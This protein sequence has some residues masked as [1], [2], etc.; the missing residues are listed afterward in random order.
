MG[1]RGADRTRGPGL[2]RGRHFRSRRARWP[3]AAA[4]FLAAALVVTGSLGA[5][6][7]AQHDSTPTAVD[8]QGNPVA[9]DEGTAPDPAHAKAMNAVDTGPDMFKVPSVGLEI[10]LG[11]MNAVGGVITP[12]GFR[13]AY[14][15]RNMGVSPDQAG[16]GTVFVV[17]HSLRGGGMGP[18]NYLID[19]Q[20][21]RSTVAVGATIEVGRLK[22]TVDGSTPI[23][24]DRLPALTGIWDSKPNRLVVITCLLRPNDATP[25]DNMV[26][27]A[28]RQP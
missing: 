8:M 25:I 20:Q 4:A 9:P 10:P 7:T 17:M 22:Y 2:L 5:V 24:K 18:G 27:T 13:S 19:V 11:A 12:P 16:S 6:F 28:T 15:V 26:I 23:S 14:W 1:R 3:L 21:A